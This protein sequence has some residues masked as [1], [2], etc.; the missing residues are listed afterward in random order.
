MSQA[1]C[2]GRPMCRP[3]HTAKIAMW[4]RG[5]RAAT[6]GGPYGIDGSRYGFTALVRSGFQPPKA[7]FEKD[8]NM[9]I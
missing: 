3:A 1:E 4:R 2:R 5:R 8:T 7:L 6:R 9:T